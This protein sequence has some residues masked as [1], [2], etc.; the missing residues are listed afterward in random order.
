[1]LMHR[2]SSK[3]GA[4]PAASPPETLPL[5]ASPPLPGPVRVRL[6]FV[7][8]GAPRVHERSV[9]R[10]TPLKALLRELGVAAEG[11]AAFRGEQPVPLDLPLE[12]DEE[13]TVLSTF[14]GG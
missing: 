8:A 5:S 4:A 7:R 2:G 10:G 13:L 14:S 11:C 9:P 3:G 6:E 1:M 12:S